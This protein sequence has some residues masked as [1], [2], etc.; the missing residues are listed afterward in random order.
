MP[1]PLGCLRYPPPATVA[2]MSDHTPVPPI[3]PRLEWDLP[4]PGVL[5]RRCHLDEFTTRVLAPNPSP[6]TL[7]GTNTYLL[8][9][10]G[11]GEV[12]VLD[13][14]PDDSGHLAAVE[15]ALA[16]RDATVRAV[17]VTHHHSDHASAA[18]PWA[19]RFGVEVHAATPEVASPDGRLLSDGDTVAVGDELLTV[20]ATPGHTGDHLSLRAPTGALLTGDHVL[21]RGTSVVAHPDG[22][23]AA[24]LDSLRRVLAL[25]PDCLYPG[26]GP[27]LTEDP[28][29]VLRYYV[30]HRRF[31]EQQLLT[32]LA[33]G[34]ATP[35]ELVSWIY[36][37]VDRRLW[38]AA[39]ASTRA[40]V[41]MLVAQGRVR[42]DDRDRVHRLDDA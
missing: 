12:V 17:V 2:G 1:S 8:G 35:G 5:A 33:T 30:D 37:D 4:A 32:A 11:A 26:H 29:A 3:D 25:G 14:G 39:E 15:D 16:E 13:P 42:V 7:D 21:G 10:P 22:D 9:P 31:R 36:A 41:E 28:S 27:A 19:R 20:V 38:P 40:A 24:Y 23:L 18:R 6:M 34:P